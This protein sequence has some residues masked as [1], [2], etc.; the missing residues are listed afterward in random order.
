MLAAAAPPLVSSPLWSKVR[1]LSSLFSLKY[2][3][4]VPL[5]L[6]VSGKAIPAPAPAADAKI[7]KQEPSTNQKS[8]RKTSS[9]FTPQLAR[10]GNTSFK[11]WEDSVNLHGPQFPPSGSKKTPPAKRPIQRSYPISHR[12]RPVGDKLTFYISNL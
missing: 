7:A 8:E 11:D 6:A 3:T 12:I 2:N 10:P 4:E 9:S 5:Q 1:S